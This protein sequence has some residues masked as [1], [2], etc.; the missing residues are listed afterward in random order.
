MKLLEID[1][2]SV[3]YHLPEKTVNAITGVS[4]SVDQGEVLG[5]IGRSGSGKTVTARAILRLVN[6]PGKIAGGRILF[7]GLNLLTISGKEMR[8]IRGTGIFMI[9]QSP[10]AVLN[11]GL[12][13]GTQLAEVLVAHG[14]LS[15]SDARNLAGEYLGKVG[16]DPAKANA[17]AFQMSLGMRQRVLIAM[18]MALRPALLIADEPTTGLDTISQKEVLNLLGILVR[19]HGM[20]MIL[21]SHDLRVIAD[22]A[23]RVAVMHE[24]YM[25]ESMEVSNFMDHARHP[26]SREMIRDYLKMQLGRNGDP[27]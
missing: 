2:L 1:N 15:W 22:Q 13:V 4:L 8:N 9:F 7:K 5:I 20:S 12:S 16:I 18:A 26:W 14:S 17:Y 10:T 19:E 25:V 6:R 21:I 23:D 11:P 24:G 27:C 3:D